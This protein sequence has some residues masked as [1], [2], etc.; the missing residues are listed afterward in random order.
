MS[1]NG[2]I[3]R[4]YLTYPKGRKA[5]K[6]AKKTQRYF[7]NTILYG[8]FGQTIMKIQCICLIM[9]ISLNFA[10]AKTYTSF[11]VEQTKVHV[12]GFFPDDWK[13]L[14]LRRSAMSRPQLKAL[15]WS[16]N[17]VSTSFEK[18]SRP[19]MYMGSNA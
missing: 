11:N 14:K 5:G 16:P 15:C 8:Y 3:K 10:L 6:Q 9:N 4:W 1:A 17:I 7:I 13:K 18:R 19:G 2:I 12:Y